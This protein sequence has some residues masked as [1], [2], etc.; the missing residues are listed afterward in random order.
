[1][2]RVA[3]QREGKIGLGWALGISVVFHVV[4]LSLLGLL[5]ALAPIGEGRPIEESVMRFSF[6][7]SADVRPSAEPLPDAAIESPRSTPQPIPL[8]PPQPSVDLRAPV[9]PGSPQPTAPAPPTAWEERRGESE[10]SPAVDLPDDPAAT[11]R[12]DPDPESAGEGD[13][14]PGFDVARAMRDFGQLIDRAREAHPL[15]APPGSGRPIRVF[16]PDL[17][18]VEQTG[19]GLGNLTFETEFDWEDYARQIYVAIWRAWHNRLLQTTD[20][21]EKWAHANGRWEL[22]HQSAVR[23]VIERSGEVTGVAIEG[24]SGC[25]P[26]DDSATQALIEVVLPPLPAAFPKQREV[27]HARFIATGDIRSMHRYLTYLKEKRKF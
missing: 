14:E 12:S 4:L 15:P 1:M 8:P 18:A 20:A 24:P 7:R 3:P 21:F 17:S 26:L 22:N 2:E 19:Y 16:Q 6:D 23:F 10:R 27:V 25:L 5:R 13:A 9:D 11:L